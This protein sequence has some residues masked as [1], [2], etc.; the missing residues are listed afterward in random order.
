[1]TPTELKTQVQQRHEACEALKELWLSLM[2]GLCPD[3]KQFALWLSLH[4]LERVVY[5]VNRTASKFAKLNGAM[6]LEH[7]VRFCSKVANTRKTELDNSNYFVR[8]S[9]ET[10]SA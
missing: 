9:H 10:Q 5:S 2:P 1:M 4:P 6:T 7:G 3:E 8:V